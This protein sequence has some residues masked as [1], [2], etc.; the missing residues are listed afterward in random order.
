[1]RR[2]VALRLLL[3]YEVIILSRYIYHI[4]RGNDIYVGQADRSEEAWEVRGRLMEHFL[5]TYYAKG[6]KDSSVKMIKSGMLQ[7]IQLHVYSDSNYGLSDECYESFFSLWNPG[8]GKTKSRRKLTAE[9]KEKTFTIQTEKAPLVVS[10]FDKLNAAEIMHSVIMQLRGYN[11]VGK[12]MGGQNVATFLNTEDSAISLNKNTSPQQALNILSRDWSAVERKKLNESVKEIMDRFWNSHLDAIVYIYTNQ[13]MKKETWKE[14][15][16]LLMTDL[17]KLGESQLDKTITISFNEHNL[18]KAIAAFL[19]SLT[20]ALAR[21]FNGM[22]VKSEKDFQQKVLEKL[23]KLNIG[24]MFPTGELITIDVKVNNNNLAFWTKHPITETNVANDSQY[25]NSLKHI[26]SLRMNYI[27][28]KS[29]KNAKTVAELSSQVESAYKDKNITITRWGK[30]FST[31][32]RTTD[33]WKNFNMKTEVLKSGKIKAVQ[34]DRMSI[35]AI[36][37]Y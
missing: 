3:Y 23:K 27:A 16:T 4:I 29:G 18:P 8:I 21:E 5:N 36:D 14:L 28:N 31:V 33:F 19:R 7:D 22:K 34:R 25:V 10:D 1:M 11:I 37:Y 26:T 13:E 35:N 17:Q 9:E 12:S 32:I 24:A 2:D 20:G 15:K 30:Y 6:Y